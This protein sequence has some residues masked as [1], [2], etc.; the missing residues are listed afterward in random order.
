MPQSKIVRAAVRTFIAKML[1]KKVLS[2]DFKYS[3]KNTE[4]EHLRY[5]GALYLFRSSRRAAE[6]CRYA[7]VRRVLSAQLPAH[8]NHCENLPE[9]PPD[10]EEAAR[11]D[12]T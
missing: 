4:T 8:W 7:A 2:D 12:S 10:G 6:E 3:L 5:R 9:D 11:R 1:V